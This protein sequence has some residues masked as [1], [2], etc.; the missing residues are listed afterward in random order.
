M[1]TREKRTALV[2][3]G[4][5]ARRLGVPATRISQWVSDGAPVHRSGRRGQPSEY[6]V[7]ALR[8]WRATRVKKT[9]ARV[10]LEEERALLARA[11]RRKLETEARTRAGKLIDVDTVVRQ[12]AAYT[13]AWS[14]MLA[15]LPRRAVQRGIPREH[16][17][18]LIDL[19]RE[20]RLEVS[21]WRTEGDIA[22]A[23]DE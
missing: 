21:A 1:T 10:S 2:S 19:V 12:G 3:R 22:Q 16:E 20:I 8:A 17:R 13:K 5:A 18:L 6:D 14:K 23:A 9:S 11:H 4:E 7:A 15:S